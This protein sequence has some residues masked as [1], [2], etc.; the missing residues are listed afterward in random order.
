MSFL[1]AL[2][3]QAWWQLGSYI[4][5]YEKMKK[6]RFRTY[7]ITTIKYHKHPLWCFS[8][9]VNKIMISDWFTGKIM[10]RYLMFKVWQFNIITIGHEMVPSSNP[11]RIPLGRCQSL[12]SL[13][14]PAAK[15]VATRAVNPGIV[16]SKP[17]IKSQ[18]FRLKPTGKHSMLKNRLFLGTIALLNNGVKKPDCRE[19]TS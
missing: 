6:E 10:Y 13:W 12:C 2:F 9:M 5:D 4:F 1:T 8:S 7:Q 15:S 14:A 17:C 16:S 18:W 11:T 19:M 3:N